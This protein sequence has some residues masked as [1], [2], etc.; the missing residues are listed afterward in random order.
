MRIKVYYYFF[1]IWLFHQFDKLLWFCRSIICCLNCHLLAY[2]FVNISY[3]Y[4]QSI[5]IK[6][7][8]FLICLIIYLL[9]IFMICFVCLY[10]CL[11]VYMS[12]FYPIFIQFNKPPSKPPARQAKAKVSFV[13][14]QLHVWFIIDVYLSI[15][16]KKEKV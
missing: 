8:F 14:L 16:L 15:T 11:S 3:D 12:V 13:C 5:S 2:Q 10:V 1:V 9:R 4:I 7:I 6:Y